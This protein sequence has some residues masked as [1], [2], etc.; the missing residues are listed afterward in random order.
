[1]KNSSVILVGSSGLIGKALQ[2]KLASTY[3]KLWAVSRKP[4]H[5]LPKTAE[6]LVVNFESDWQTTSWPKCDALFCALGTTIKTAGSQQAFRKVDFDYVVNS[7]HAAKRAGATK[8]AVVSALGATSK[9]SVFY[10]RTKGEMEDALIALGFASLLIV[11]PSFLS[12][13][14]QALGQDSRLGEKLAL[15]ISSAL[16]PIIPKK[17]RAISAD[18]V[19]GCMVDRLDTMTSS[20]EIIESGELQQWQNWQQR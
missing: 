15:T 5:D 1:M 4:M 13:D 10:S 11:R 8:M 20:V 9:S 2:A 7:A 16:N 18:A 17:Y 14:R 6:N 3:T 19:A 12:G